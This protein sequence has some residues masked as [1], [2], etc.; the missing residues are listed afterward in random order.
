VTENK[1]VQTGGLR[2]TKRKKTDEK[3]EEKKYRK[4]G[5]YEDMKLKLHIFSFSA[6]SGG[7]NKIFFKFINTLITMI[8]Y[9]T[10]T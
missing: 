4:K 8:R 7:K 10:T 5:N 6:P 2:Q 9:T 1:C 3:E